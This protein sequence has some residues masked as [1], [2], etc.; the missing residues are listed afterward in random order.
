MMKTFNV[1]LV[2][3]KKLK[4]KNIDGVRH[5]IVEG[6]ESTIAFPSVTVVLGADKEKQKSLHEWR[7]RVG[8]DKAN[9]IARKASSRGT[10]VHNMIEDYLKGNDPEAD[11]SSYL[12]NSMFRELKRAADEHVDNIRSIEGQMYSKHLRAAGTVDLIAEFDGKLS[13]IDWKTAARLKSRDHVTSY[14]VQESAYAV[15]FE[16]LYGIPVAQLV[17]I[18]VTED[19]ECQIFIEKRDDWIG[20]FLELREMYDNVGV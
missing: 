15:M 1:D 20:R 11:S 3:P 10:A 6:D 16:E 7:R 4:R 19:A 9:E 2:E 18:L 14:F 13:V 5:Y 8:F 17:T 12:H